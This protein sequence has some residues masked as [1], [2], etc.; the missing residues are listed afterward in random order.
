MHKLMS[1]RT[2]TTNSNSQPLD[3]RWA[4]GSRRHG[5]QGLVGLQLACCE[6]APRTN[7]PHGHKLPAVR[8]RAKGIAFRCRGTCANFAVRR[9]MAAMLTRPWDNSTVV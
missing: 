3:L 5:G 9:F 1:V 6:K 8:G 2:R 7:C 4:R